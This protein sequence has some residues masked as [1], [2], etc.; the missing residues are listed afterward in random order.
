MSISNLGSIRE[1]L[2]QAT[3]LLG[4]RHPVTNMSDLYERLT[5]RVPVEHAV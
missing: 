2:F 5:A 1:D 3:V 4:G